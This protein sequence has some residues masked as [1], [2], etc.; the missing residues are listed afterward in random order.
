MEFIRPIESHQEPTVAVRD[1]S[2]YGLRFV[3]CPHFMYQV[4]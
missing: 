3:A 1:D 4:L 2:E